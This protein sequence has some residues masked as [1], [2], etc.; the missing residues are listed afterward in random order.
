MAALVVTFIAGAL[1]G[2][3]FER[4]VAADPAPAA[5]GRGRMALQ[6]RGRA[7]ARGSPIA[8]R[9]HL[10]EEQQVRIDSILSADR[11]K[12]RVVLGQIRPLLQARYDS[13]TSA[14]RA[15][16]TPEQREEFRRLRMERRRQLR[17][18]FDAGSRPRQ[19][20]DE[21]M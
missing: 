12:A 20:A 15:V 2:V 5:F 16:L 1:V 19:P 21:A 14:I 10:S 4:V 13:T 17:R 9:L 8:Q 18:Q 3:A 7:F 11:A 6:P